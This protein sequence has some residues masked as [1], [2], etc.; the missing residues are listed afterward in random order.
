[1]DIKV[2]VIITHTEIIPDLII[3]ATIEVLH[4]AITPA[5]TVIAVT[6]HTTD[7]FHIGVLWH[8]QEIIADSDHDLHTDQVRNHNISLHSYIVEPQQNLQVEGIPE[9]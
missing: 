8:T 9:S 4:D 2:I 7:H 5:L 1:M 3:D 6:H